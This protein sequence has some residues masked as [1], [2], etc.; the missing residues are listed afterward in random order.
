MMTTLLIKNPLLVA[1]VNDAGTEFSGGHILIEDGV[2]KSIGPEPLDIQAD[3]II[4]ADGMVITPGFINT[5]H[6]LY[7]TLTRNIPLMQD[8]PLFPWLTNHYEVWREVTTEAIHVSTQTGLL[9]LMKSGVTTSSDHL[10]LFP[11]QA[12]PELIDTEIEA[13]RSL[14]IRFQPTRGSMSLGKS[15]GGLPP[16]DVVQTEAVIQA[17]TERLVAKYHDTSPGAMTRISLAPCSPF[18]VTAELMRQTAA[19]AR[20]NHLQIHTHLAETLDEE[21]FCLETSG[22]RPV[23]LMQELDWLSENSWYAHTVHLNDAEI[24]VMGENQVGMSHCPSS[25]MRLGS[26][27]ARIRELLDAGVN[28]SLGVDGSASNDSGDMLLEMRNALLISRLRDEPYW[29]TARD[30]LRM[31]TRG[32]AAALGR[33]DIGELAIGKQADLALFNMNGLSQAGS[34]SDPIGSLVFTTRS[35]SVDYLI[36]QGRIIYDH[37]KTDFNESKLIR[38]QNQI[39][40]EMIRRAQKRTGINFLNRINGPS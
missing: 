40:G 15:K 3:Q 18:S 38:E 5:H 32:G 37:G 25:N 13:A 6:H 23:G 8:Q 20:E 22:H 14:G 9:E 35:Q 19:Y 34:L 21:K 24:K 31:A 12:S 28:V 29:L 7:Q 33:D 2:I 30:V 11:N 1:T 36:V 39:A 10:Y 27:I 16:D 4:N 17:D 26:G